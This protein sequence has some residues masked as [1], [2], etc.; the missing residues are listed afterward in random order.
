MLAVTNSAGKQT[1]ISMRYCIKSTWNLCLTWNGVCFLLCC[2]AKTS[3]MQ[4]QGKGYRQGWEGAC[5][6]HRN[7]L[8]FIFKMYCLCLCI[9]GECDTQAH[10]P[11]SEDG[12]QELVLF[13]HVGPGGW[14]Q[15]IKLE[16]Q[17]AS[18][19]TE[20]SHQPRKSQQTNNKHF[21][22][23]YGVRSWELSLSLRINCLMFVSSV[24]YSKSKTSNIIS[25]W[26]EK[27]KLCTD[28]P[29]EKGNRN[30]QTRTLSVPCLA[31]PSIS[32]T[33][34]KDRL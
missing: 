33:R 32:S 3:T 21:K 1:P 31:S 11:K 23:L 34:R 12:F 16:R 27:A 4:G 6:K 8:N 25:S 7:T 18:L 9:W 15:V 10:M 26:E 22:A 17:Q 20:P 30:R 13:L 19:S 29:V 24:D 14:V 2:R 5:R 28:C